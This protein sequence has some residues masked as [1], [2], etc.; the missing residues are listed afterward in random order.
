[1]KYQ[2]NRFQFSIVMLK[3]RILVGFFLASVLDYGNLSSLRVPQTI[4]SCRKQNLRGFNLHWT[5]VSGETEFSEIWLTD[6]KFKLKST[7]IRHSI[8]L[9]S[10]LNLSFKWCWHIIGSLFD[11]LGCILLSEIETVI[12][13]DRRFEQTDRHTYR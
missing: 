7:G 4:D 3:S 8:V 9:Y 11:K 6:V 13:T 2:K 10:T 5:S 1:M 12:Q